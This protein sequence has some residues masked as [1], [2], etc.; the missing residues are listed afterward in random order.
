[1]ADRAINTMASVLYDAVAVPCGPDS[2][3]ALA[4]DGYAVHFVT[5]AY[6]HAKPVAAFGAGV[7]LLAKAGVDPKVAR[8]ED[9]LVVDAGVV[10]STRAQDALPADF[11]E[12]FAGLIAGHRVWSRDTA[13]V[14]A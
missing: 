12:R 1:M 2:V 9:E 14:P 11:A 13:A 4:A 8:G 7:D 10:T 3:A 6:K 5:E